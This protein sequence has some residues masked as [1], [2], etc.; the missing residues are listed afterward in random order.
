[1]KIEDI[2]PEATL[3]NYDTE[4]K[5]ILSDEA[6][7]KGEAKEKALSWI[8][9][10]SAFANCRGGFLYVGVQDSNHIIVPL[11]EELV[12]QQC[13]L[14]YRELE[15]RLSFPIKTEIKTFPIKSNGKKLFIISFHVFPSQ[16]KPVAIK[17]N[18][19]NLIYTRDFGRTRSANIDEITNMVLQSE[20]IYYDSKITNITYNP[21]N[22]TH[23]NKRYQ[24]ADDGKELAEKALISIGFINEEK[25]LSQGALL[26]ADDCKS[27]LTR[28]MAVKWPGI[29]K[30]SSTYQ[31][32]EEFTGNLIDAIEFGKSFVF[33][34]SN[35]G[36]TKTE[37]GLINYR[38]YPARSVEEGLANAVGHRDYFI[39]GSQIE[40][41]IYID[42][43]E[44]TSPGSLLGVTSL[45]KEKNIAAIAPRRRNKIITST[46]SLC[47]YMDKMGSGFDL[48]EEE[49]SGYGEGHKPYISSDESSFTLTLPDLTFA[50]GIIGDTNKIPTIIVIP[51]VQGK[52]DLKILAYCYP[53]ERTAGEIAKYLGITNSTHFRKE[54]LGNLEQK[55]YLH[56]NIEGRYPLYSSSKS[57]VHPVG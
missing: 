30:G 47:D 24:E 28:I 1:M 32:K 15:Q 21:Q 43:L 39:N 10:I 4:F 51:P 20:N 49:Y 53:R 41:N 29:D 50:S 3:E 12:N 34:H 46:L 6:K 23:L 19:G 52:Y 11:T 8:R 18:G 7:E 13:L 44:I 26:F 36:A 35:K 55:E 37:D 57:K 31:D 40:I 5:Q 45:S 42:R 9:T 33:S 17:A 27:P 16:R 48:I 38:S 14:F 22:F 54:T 56:T 25:K 2:V